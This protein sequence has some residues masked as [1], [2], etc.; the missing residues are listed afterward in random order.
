MQKKHDKLKRLHSTVNLAFSNLQQLIPRIGDINGQVTEK[1]ESLAKL[2]ADVEAAQK[3]EKELQKQ[4]DETREEIAKFDVTELESARKLQKSAFTDHLNAKH[5]MDS[6][7]QR[8]ADLALRVDELKERLDNAQK[9][10]ERKEKI[11]KLLGIVDRIRV[12]YRSIQPK[13]R[14]EFVT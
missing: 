10:I 9:K 3:Q 12:A 13:L 2:A 14:G 8:K 6:L 5:E 1:Q 11:G 7:K 4:L